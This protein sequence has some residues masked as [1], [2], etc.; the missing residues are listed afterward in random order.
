MPLS[1]KILLHRQKRGVL[2]LRELKKLFP[3]AKI[4]LIYKNHWEL[5]VAVILSAQCTDKMVNRVTPAL[6]KKYTTLDAYVHADS[7]EFEKIVFKT[8]FYRNKTK[9]IL[10]AARVVQ[11][12]FN[13]KIP[14]TMPE[15]LTIPGVARKTANVVLGNAY[16]IVAGIAVD[17]HVR[18]LSQVLGLTTHHDPNKIEQDLMQIFPQKEWFALT[19]R[20]IEYGRTYCSARK[21]DH[22]QCPLSMTV[23]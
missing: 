14:R 17:T 8:G 10:G 16:G 23:R 12:N 20:L 3:D 4:A 21:H 11:K 1:P 6:F 2:I 22:A 13:G 19:Y 15:M 7:Q 5:L 18:R 9:N